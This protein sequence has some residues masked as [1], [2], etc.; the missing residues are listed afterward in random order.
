[1]KLD[2]NK[3][4]CSASTRITKAD[5]CKAA[6]VAVGNPHAQPLP[7]PNPNLT[8][9]LN[10]NPHPYPNLTNLNPHLDPN[11]NAN[12]RWATPQK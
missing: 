2:K 6:G 7:D 12:P 10:P 8:R 1:M 5:E 4:G 9:T 3:A 11:G